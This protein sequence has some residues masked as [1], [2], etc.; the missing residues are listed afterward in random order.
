MAMLLH[1]Q[2]RCL[3]AMQQQQQQQLQGSSTA[4]QLALPSD[5]HW[6]EQRVMGFT[7]QLTV[8]QGAVTQPGAP[9]NPGAEAQVE[10]SFSTGTE[11]QLSSMA[12]PSDPL[13]APTASSLLESPALQQLSR[14]MVQALYGCA[15]LQHRPSQQWL[16]AFFTHTAD[17]AHSIPCATLSCGLRSLA[18]LHCRPSTHW[19]QHVLEASLGRWDGCSGAAVSSLMW[20]LATLR[21]APNPD[22]MRRF[23]AN[24]CVGD[25][26]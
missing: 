4:L 3:Q 16:E 19:M 10:D 26:W 23:F 9:A 8:P 7:E 12:S 6:H 5:E 24:V 14:S 2:L 20:S 15:L 21:H 1:Q 25:G 17:H 18:A 22:W 11:Q 13:T